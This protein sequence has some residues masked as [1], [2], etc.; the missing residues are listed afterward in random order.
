MRWKLECPVCRQ[1]INPGSLLS[2]REKVVLQIYELEPL[3]WGGLKDPMISLS[4]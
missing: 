1:E 4:S 3:F 2:L